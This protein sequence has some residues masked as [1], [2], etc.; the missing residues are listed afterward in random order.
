LDAAANWHYGHVWTEVAA[1]QAGISDQTPL[2]TDQGTLAEY[3][4]N[5]GNF[6][7]LGNVFRR[8]DPIS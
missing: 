7:L 8:P 4:Q 6:Q 5:W 2:L 3:F 1:T